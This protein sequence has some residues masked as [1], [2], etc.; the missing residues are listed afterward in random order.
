MEEHTE[1]ASYSKKTRAMCTDKSLHKLNN[2]VNCP[3]KTPVKIQYFVIA[4][5]LIWRNHFLNEGEAVTNN[6]ERQL[7]E[8]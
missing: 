2:T 8:K 6:R 7:N 1:R 5:K 4:R 3:A